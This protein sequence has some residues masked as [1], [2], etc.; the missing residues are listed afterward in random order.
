MSSFVSLE[1]RRYVAPNGGNFVICTDLVAEPD[2]QA[3][4]RRLIDVCDD[5][6]AWAVYVEF[7]W[8]QSSSKSDGAFT[9]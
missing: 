5:T 3:A 6:H 2:V 1:G 9:T 7:S 4:S 8:G